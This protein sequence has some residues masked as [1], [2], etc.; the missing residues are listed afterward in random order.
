MHSWFDTSHRYQPT[1]PW[2]GKKER[3]FRTV[4]QEDFGARCH[5]MTC[6]NVRRVPSSTR[7][8]FQARQYSTYLLVV[9]QAA[10]RK[11]DSVCARRK[12][13]LA[14]WH[15]ADSSRSRRPKSDAGIH[16]IYEVA[17]STFKRVRDHGDHIQRLQRQKRRS[18]KYFIYSLHRYFP[19]GWYHKHNEQI[20]HERGV[21]WYYRAKWSPGRLLT[22][23]K[24]L[25]CFNDKPLKKHVP[26]SEPRPVRA[27][28]GT[29]PST[30]PSSL[31]ACRLGR[32]GN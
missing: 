32:R 25:A 22:T 27:P 28:G 4:K 21:E 19:V 23:V 30:S 14:V 20:R 5:E 3:H 7:D 10:R 2:Q 12:R 16:P 9:R 26:Q 24:F 1:G 11:Q 15:L 6:R 18:E 29:H 17:Q 13:C 8:Y 31:S